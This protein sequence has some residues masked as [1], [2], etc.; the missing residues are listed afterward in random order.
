MSISAL[1]KSSTV[2]YSSVFL[3]TVQRLSTIASKSLA[4]SEH[5]ADATVAVYAAQ[6]QI[7]NYYENY[8]NCS[9]SET[10]S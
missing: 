2:S 1:I 6:Q 3:Y 9:G 5:Q 10:N 8:F 7:R 4:K